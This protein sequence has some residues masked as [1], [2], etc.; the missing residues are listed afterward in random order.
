MFIKSFEA[1]NLSENVDS[2]V[3][4]IWIVQFVSNRSSDLDF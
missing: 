3:S 2:P 1:N 4:I